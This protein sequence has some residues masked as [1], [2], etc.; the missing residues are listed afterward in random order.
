MI[1][2]RLEVEGFRCF[3]SKVAVGLDPERIN[4]L[5]GGNG[6]GKSSL[7]WALVRGIFDTYRAGGK[8]VEGLRPWGT[9][10][11]P[12]ILIE[13]EH[14]GKV[15]RL[16]KSFL[17]DRGTDLHEKQGNKFKPL[18]HNEK[19]EERIREMLLADQ[20]TVGLCKPEKWGLARALWCPQEH[21][22]IDGFDGR[23]L[24][25]IQELLGKQGMDDHALELNGTVEEAFLEYWTDKGKPKGGKGAPLWVRRQAELTS[26]QEDLAASERELEDLRAAQET[27]KALQEERLKMQNQLGE[28]R[29]AAGQLQAKADEYVPLVSLCDKLKAQWEGKR[30]EAVVLEG[31]VKR[32]AEIREKQERSTGRLDDWLRQ[33]PA[34]RPASKNSKPCSTKLTNR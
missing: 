16:E 15:F 23:L 1:L 5:H 20:P 21:L 9:D 32:V 12:A 17:E 2:Q 19:A 25:S 4:I 18:A 27:A 6:T 3:T 11:S 30:A 22:A 8:S 10:L 7:L 28:A 24:S 29:D 13:F 33:S 31:T 34:R 14:G 26:R